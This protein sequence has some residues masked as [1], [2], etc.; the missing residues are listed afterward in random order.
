MWLQEVMMN[1]RKSYVFKHSVQCS[2]RLA[3]LMP[4]I[5]L[6][7]MFMESVFTHVYTNVFTPT[8]T[9]KH[10]HIQAQY[11]SDILAWKFVAFRVP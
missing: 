5:V 2:L 4:C 3:P 10:A 8:F 1:D 11:F 9:H 7:Q 6:V